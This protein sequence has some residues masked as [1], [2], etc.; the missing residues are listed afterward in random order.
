[1]EAQISG[2]E[3]AGAG[4]IPGDFWNVGNG[5]TE[6]GRI[7]GIPIRAVR[8][9]VS[10][11][12]IGAADGDVVGRRS[13]GVDGYA[14][15][16]FRNTIVATGRAAVTGGDENGNTLGDGLLIGGIVGGICGG[17]VHGFAL[18]VTDADDGGRPSAGVDEVLHGDQ[19]A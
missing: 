18:A 8:A 15:S 10:V 6:G 19:A 13:E 9:R 16:S 1:M 11:A 7:A 3:C 12:E 17:S 5:G 14:V 4:V 2:E